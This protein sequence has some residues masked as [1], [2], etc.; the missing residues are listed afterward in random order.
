MS[1]LKKMFYW[2]I[3]RMILV[4]INTM[5]PRLTNDSLRT[6]LANEMFCCIY[7]SSNEMFRCMYD[8]TNEMLR[9][10]HALR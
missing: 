4:G 9:G 8:S 2:M 1:N 7:D 3:L 10:M 5:I 6:V